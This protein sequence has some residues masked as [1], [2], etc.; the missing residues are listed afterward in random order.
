[1]R[2]LVQI[3][4]FTPDV[5]R[6]RAFYEQGIGLHPVYAG[7]NWTSY[8][9]AGA[10]L[11]LHPL[12]GRHGRELELTFESHN[13]LADVEAMRARGVDTFG[14]IQ[15]QSYGTT[16]QFRDPEGN[17]LALRQGGDLPAEA[18]PRIATVIVNVRDLG[19]ALAFYRDRLGLSPAFESAHRV[20]FD[21]GA[22]RIALQA[23]QAGLD[24]PFHAGQRVA[25]CFEADDLDAWV[26]DIRAHDVTFATAPAGGDFGLHAEAV[27][28][29]GNVV[30]F[31][32]EPAAPTPDEELAEPFEE[33][34]STHPVA[35]R[36]PVKKGS[37]AM[38]RL[39]LKPVYH[40]KKEHRKPLSATTR[41]VVSVRG[42]G[43]EKTR[44]RPK[45]TADERKAKVKPAVGHQQQATL[46]AER[47][48]R[49]ATATASKS[50][51][52]KRAAAVRSRK[53]RATS[54]PSG[55]RGR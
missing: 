30:L 14:E 28:A 17:L 45:R 46:K 36:K 40:E 7:P 4:V 12:A 41:A 34:V 2:R 8:R 44:L 31:R 26:D 19:G 54:R 16:I 39:V 32:E 18:G 5:E 43:P 33:D 29:D 21:A 25:F 11:A 48:L 50:R 42:A 23:R 52:V 37:K 55:R 27:D 9:T 35:F 6:M 53:S 1:M 38:S 22:T 20:E 51:P 49:S 47:R 3:I 24:H 15:G 13:I 10:T